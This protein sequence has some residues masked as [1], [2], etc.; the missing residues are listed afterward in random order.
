M[1]ASL[2]DGAG[3]SPGGKGG[4]TGGGAAGGAGGGSEGG[5][6]GSGWQ[7]PSFHSQQRVHQGNLSSSVQYLSAGVPL[8]LHTAP[9]Q[10][11][12]AS[13]CAHSLIDRGGTRQSSGGI[14]GGDGAAG[15]GGGSDGHAMQTPQVAWQ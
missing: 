5:A 11:A 10:P 15:G 13:G 14:P 6:S 12:S 7:L 3:A 1:T 8:L 9:A 4:T 2:H